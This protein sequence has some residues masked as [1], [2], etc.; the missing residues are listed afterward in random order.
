MQNFKKL[1]NLELGQ[2]K[3]VFDSNRADYQVLATWVQNAMG[4]FYTDKLSDKCDSN[5]FTVSP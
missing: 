2:H 3:L 4:M 5:I 1:P